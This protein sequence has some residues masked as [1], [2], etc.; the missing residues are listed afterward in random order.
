MSIEIEKFNSDMSQ[1]HILLVL[2]AVNKTAFEKRISD[3]RAKN[4]NAVNTGL[5]DKDYCGASTIDRTISTIFPVDKIINGTI[6]FDKVSTNEDAMALLKPYTYYDTIPKYIQNFGDKDAPCNL[7]CYSKTHNGDEYNI[8]TLEISREIIM[9]VIIIYNTIYDE[10]VV[11]N[12]KYN[13]RSSPLAK[14]EKCRED[15][16]EI[17]EDV[18]LHN[19]IIQTAMC[20]HK[21]YI[22]SGNKL[23]A[24]TKLELLKKITNN[25]LDNPEPIT[26]DTTS[27]YSSSE[28]PAPMESENSDT[29]MEIDIRSNVDAY[30]HNLSVFKIKPF[31]YQMATVDWAIRTMNNVCNTKF[32]HDTSREI[33]YG[34]I[35]QN[36]LYGTFNMTVY[37]A[38]IQQ[39]GIC[40]I[41]DR[42]LGKTFEAV[43]LIEYNKAPA[44]FIGEHTPEEVDP[45]NIYYAKQN[46]DTPPTINVDVLCAR[47]RTR[48]SLVIVPDNVAHQWVSEIGKYYNDDICVFNNIG[49][50]KKSNNI[51][52]LCTEVTN[53][54]RNNFR[55]VY[56]LFSNDNMQHF[57]DNADAL[58]SGENAV[59]M[60]IITFNM[61]ATLPAILTKYFWWM[62][63]IDE[64]HEIL[65]ETDVSILTPTGNSVQTKVI[66]DYLKGF[67]S[68]DAK[69][70]KITG[71]KSNFKVFLSGTP[72]T[73]SD[74]YAQYVWQ[75]FEGRFTKSSY[76]QSHILTDHVIKNLARRNT[77]ANTS[78]S[79]PPIVTTKKWLTLTEKEQQIY[80][81]VF[82]NNGDPFSDILR[83]LCC[84]PL[85]YGGIKQFVQGS[86]NINEL[87]ECYKSHFKM[88][89]DKKMSQFI[90]KEEEF[91]MY[92]VFIKTFVQAMGILDI[93]FMR[94]RMNTED[95]KEYTEFQAIFK[96]YCEEH[97]INMYQ[98]YNDKTLSQTFPLNIENIMMIICNIFHPIE[99]SYSINTIYKDKDIASSF[100]TS[101]ISDQYKVKLI[102]DIID[103][104]TRI[105]KI[106]TDSKRLRSTDSNHFEKWFRHANNGSGMFSAYQ[107]GNVYELMLDGY[108]IISRILINTIDDKSIST[109]CITLLEDISIKNRSVPS[110]MEIIKL[111]E[112]V[113][114]RIVDYYNKAADNYNSS[115]LEAKK[116]NGS[117]AY[118][119]AR[120]SIEQLQ[121]KIS[122]DY[123]KNNC[124]YSATEEDCSICLE[125]YIGFDDHD[126]EF[127]APIIKRIT[128]LPCGHYYCSSCYEHCS[129]TNNA[130][131]NCRFVVKDKETAMKCVDISVKKLALQNNDAIFRTDLDNLIE[132]EGTKTSYIIQY[133]KGHSDEHILVF[134]IWEK[135]L[136]RIKNQ[137]ETNDIRCLYCVGSPAEK[138]D[139][140]REF[141]EG[142]TNDCSRVMLLSAQNCVSGVTL[143]RASKIIYV[144]PF[145]G[146]PEYR[147]Q[148]ELQANA[149]VRR[150]GQTADK[151]EQIWFLTTNTCEQIIDTANQTF[152]SSQN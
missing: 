133:I 91:N 126:E 77:E 12:P 26:V 39:Y 101:D 146:T 70:G 96:K 103:N 76:I 56:T 4:P 9:N 143:T 32:H 78:V 15:Y 108:Q 68:Q 137:L 119:E 35:F 117:F 118:L 43:M 67:N 58:L 83:E 27:F 127:Q 130:C 109:H 64:A 19:Y 89:Y 10:K 57:A 115:K 102:Q 29:P 106:I 53:E 139:I 48:T 122:D 6:I 50:P 2:Y 135:A 90:E 125:P 111:Q 100:N 45:H 134:C 95:A 92:D 93:K 124:K 22:S 16:P 63:I 74:N 11:K 128:L 141:Q 62:V 28:Q 13:I 149:R 20:N 81:A 114:T 94:G 144:T 52:K 61:L 21:L 34:N 147:R 54:E 44:S 42:G 5:P 142:R 151:I 148:Q 60:V 24:D 73:Y 99:S 123:Y 66:C 152:Q 17:Y 113:T 7:Y 33:V 150:I 38:W 25:I 107:A 86:M 112:A 51:V 37:R 116:S 1:S 82:M 140:I 131:P 129:R 121:Q 136:I 69:G 55:L 75:L 31:P 98:Y 104:C 47:P 105:D 145:Y 88:V 40:I 59:D 80:D 85:I 120:A 65:T 132:K 97:H 18:I 79:L 14:L 87:R 36:S 46:S 8:F 138:N 84:N 71:V 23:T 72:F 41:D 110:P 3:E 49:K 30:R